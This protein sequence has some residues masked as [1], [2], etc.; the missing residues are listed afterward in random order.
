MLPDLPDVTLVAATSIA[1]DQTLE[2]L[3]LSMREVRCGRILLLSDRP[4]EGC[5]ARG[6]EWRR[7]QPIRSRSD[8]SRFMLRELSAHIST[9]HALCIQWDGYVLD[10]GRWDPRFLDH[11]YIGAPWPH[12]HDEYRVGNGGF[13]LRS[14]R[15]LEACTKLPTDSTHAEDVLIARIFRPVLE[16]QGIRFAP[17]SLARH[18]AYERLK[19]TGHEFGFHGAFNLVRL[20]SP[21]VATELFRN[22]EP[23]VLARSERWELLRWALAHGRWKLAATLLRRLV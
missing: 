12:F 6:I 3:C 5:G 7:I 9:K 13:S 15:L 1:L 21:N 19:P 11:D 17:E 10:G 8:Y 18:F 2:A 20:L 23:V 16:D 4:V 14:K 22:L